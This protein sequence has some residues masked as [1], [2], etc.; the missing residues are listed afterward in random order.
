MTTLLKN[1]FMSNLSQIL[2]S[3]GQ[4]NKWIGTTGFVYG[5]GERSGDEISFYDKQFTFTSNVI[6]DIDINSTTGEVLSRQ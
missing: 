1:Y 2:Q 4:T 5:I 6:N 3:M